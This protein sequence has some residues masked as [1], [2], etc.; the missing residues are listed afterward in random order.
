MSSDDHVV[1]EWYFNDLLGHKAKLPSPGFGV[2]Y[3]KCLMDII[4]ADGVI[5]HAERKWVIG[6]AAI[7]GEFS[8]EI[9]YDGVCI[10][11]VT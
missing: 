4:A 7:S 11:F 5:S 8:E 3:S 10:I 2:F 6:F 1:G 9:G